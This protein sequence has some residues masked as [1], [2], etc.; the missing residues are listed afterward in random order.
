[1]IL[2][3]N[4]DYRLKGY[5]RKNVY[6]TYGDIEA[7]EYYAE[8]NAPTKEYKGLKVKETRVVLR[9]QTFGVPY[10]ESIDIEWFKSD[11]TTMANK[12]LVEVFDENQGQLLNQSARANLVTKAQAY[13][14]QSAGLENAKNFGETYIAERDMY[15]AGV[16]NPLITVITNATEPYMTQQIKDNL[17]LILN[18]SY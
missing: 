1:M 18:I 14:F 2:V 8:F 7:V 12:R 3:T 10:E 16:T 13:L 5:F 4:E 17:V 15:L 6:N 11:G 9:D